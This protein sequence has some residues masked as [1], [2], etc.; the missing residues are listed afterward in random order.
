MIKTK[1]VKKQIISSEV[2]DIICNKCGKTCDN[3]KRYY[4]SNTPN[5][6]GVENLRID[7]GYMSEFFGDMTSIQ[8]S[9]CEKCILDF[10]KA[11]KIPHEI[12][13]E[14]TDGFVSS[15]KY[16]SILKNFEKRYKK[17]IAK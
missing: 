5:Y 15:K 6:E 16:P 1:K 11:F 3:A 7:F 2:V 10:T 9:V 8:F 13:T 4:K 17:I 12:K 14:I